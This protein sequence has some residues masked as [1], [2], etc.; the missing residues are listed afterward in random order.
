MTIK[1]IR[2]ESDHK[3]AIA[4]LKELWGA[5][6]DTPEGEEFEVLFTLVEAYEAKQ[7]PIAPP[8]PIEAI[9]FRMEQESMTNTD[10]ARYLGYKSRVSEILSGKRKLTV[11]M[12][13]VLHHKLGIPA[14]SLLSD[15]GAAA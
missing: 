1:P 10:L 13:Q 2:T 12:M 11:R 9:K 15:T 3:Q 4:R 7:Y 6:K 8:D 14:E 5:E